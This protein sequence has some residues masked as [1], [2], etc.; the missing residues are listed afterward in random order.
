MQFNDDTRENTLSEL[1]KVISREEIEGF[2]RE[3]VNLQQLYNSGI[4]EIKTKLEILDD[5]FRVRFDHNP[6]HHIEYRLKSPKSIVEKLQRKGCPVS[7]QSVR[8][9]LYD[10]AGVRVICNYIDDIY[11]IVDF[12][13]MQDDIHVVRIRDYI[14]EPK[15]N[16][17]RS[18]HMVVN[19]PVFLSTGKESVNVEIQ[20]RT[21]A[22]DF[23]ASLEH[24]LK[25]KSSA[26]SGEKVKKLLTECADEIN[27]VDRKM[28]D[29]YKELFE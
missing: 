11:K 25:Y 18:L 2:M 13:S 1:T 15:K 7:I 26:Q 17:Y 9:N 8:E 22:M 24:Q 29:I 3:F 14:K 21:I 20:I 28:Q 4:K 23:W 19:I 10:V 27:E 5:E 6:V 16:G 12:L